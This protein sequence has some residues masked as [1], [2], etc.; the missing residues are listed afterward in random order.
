MVEFLRGQW[1]D[2]REVLDHYSI[3]YMEGLLL[4]PVV[5]AALFYPFEVLMGVV[6]ALLVGLAAFEAFE[7]FRY[8]PRRRHKHVSTFRYPL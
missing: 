2:L 1:K 7:W 5:M 3:V 6:G 4:V 8:H